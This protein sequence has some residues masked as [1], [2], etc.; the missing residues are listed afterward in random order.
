MIMS[1]HRKKAFV[2]ISHSVMIRSLKTR[3]GKNFV[4]LIKGF[5]EK[6][7]ATITLIGERQCCFL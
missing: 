2:N 4:N 5:F 3:V 7:A 6:S 1:T